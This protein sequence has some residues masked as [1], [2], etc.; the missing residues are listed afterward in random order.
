MTGVITDACIKCKHMDCVEVCPVDAF[1]EGENMLVINPQECVDCGCCIEECP[2]DAIV[3]E[4][5]P[6][7]GPWLELN[8]KYSELWPNVTFNGGQTPPDAEQFHAMAGK[9]ERYFS[10]EPGRGDTGSRIRLLPQKPCN[11]CGKETV[12]ERLIRMIRKLSI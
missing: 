12:L 2:I 3:F 8:K 4:D 10:A 11:K 5:D 9:F 1:Y 6:L 7:A